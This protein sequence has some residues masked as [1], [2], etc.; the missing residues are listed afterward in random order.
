MITTDKL[1]NE[2]NKVPYKADILFNYIQ[3]S[4]ILYCVKYKTESNRFIIYVGNNRIKNIVRK[5]KDNL[6][7]KKLP[8]IILNENEPTKIYYIEEICND[9]ESYNEINVYYLEKELVIE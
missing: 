9:F 7:N 6:Y 8:I 2:I 4:S 1:L 3:D 5:L